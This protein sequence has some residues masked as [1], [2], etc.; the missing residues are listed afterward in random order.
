MIKKFLP[1][2]FL[3]SCNSYA[4]GEKTFYPPWPDSGS[5]PNYSGYVC[6]D[7]GFGGG[8]VACDPATNS[9][10][11]LNYDNNPQKWAC[12]VDHYTNTCRTYWKEGWCFIRSNGRCF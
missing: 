6:R 7:D 10:M 5:N 1:V 12:S 4:S 8:R 9:N 3:L 11:H 2:L